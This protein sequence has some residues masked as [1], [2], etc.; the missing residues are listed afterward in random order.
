M[1]SGIG[2]RR[3]GEER[4][5]RG[6]KTEPPRW[7]RVAAL[8]DSLRQL[9]EPRRRELKRLLASSSELLHPISE[10]LLLE[11]PLTSQLGKLREESYSD[12]LA[13][14][15]EQLEPARAL[16]ALGL[17]PA[18]A[19]S[20]APFEAKRE[21]YVM[22]DRTTSFGRIDIRLLASGREIVDIEV[23]LGDA[24]SEDLHQLQVYGRSGNAARVLI[25][26]SGSKLIYHKFHLRKWEEVC[27]SLRH[28]VRG[29]IRKRT[30]LQASWMLQFVAAVE[31]N[32]LKIRGPLLRAICNRD[33][34][35]IVGEAGYETEH[36]RRCISSQ[37]RNG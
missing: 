1:K 14:C 2:S 32:L 36:L 11:N 10:P 31:E 7:T 22:S 18:L 26:T 4:R 15:L 8:V 12:W 30:L 35:L 20:D 24:D 28:A 17:N 27:I 6:V 19:V 25:A 23:K 5:G 9:E 3:E 16:V 29:L 21:R 33:E 34:R 37:E 13:W